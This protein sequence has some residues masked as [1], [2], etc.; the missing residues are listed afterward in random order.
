[1][2]VDNG[3]GSFLPCGPVSI[4]GTQTGPSVFFGTG[5]S[6]GGVDI[7]AFAG[8]TLLVR[9]QDGVTPILRND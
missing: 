1:V 2:F 9:Q 6:F 5:V 8:H 3:N 7:G 4:N